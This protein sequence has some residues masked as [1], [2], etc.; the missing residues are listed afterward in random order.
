M[1]MVR[2]ILWFGE[3]HV[4]ECI[5]AGN[6]IAV[7][8]MVG[9]RRHVS[10]VADVRIAMRCSVRRFEFAKAS[11]ETRISMSHSYRVQSKLNQNSRAVEKEWKK[12]ITPCLVVY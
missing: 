2:H 5:R 10:C 11:L 7:G 1:G 6:E 8:L 12:L 3:R 4:F 9:A